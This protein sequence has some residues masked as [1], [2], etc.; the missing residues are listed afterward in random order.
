MTAGRRR[1]LQVVRMQIRIGGSILV[2]CAGEEITIE[3][4]QFGLEEDGARNLGDGD[5]QYE[6]L[7]IYFDPEHRFKLLVESTMLHKKLTLYPAT[8]NGAAVIVDDEFD[9]AAL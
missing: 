3:G 9:A 1:S 2:A 8:V 4:S 6:A 7:H 5:L